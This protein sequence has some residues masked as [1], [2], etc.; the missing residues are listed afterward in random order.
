M[1][2]EATVHHLPTACHAAEPGNGRSGISG[3][4]NALD[5]LDIV[6][7]TPFWR[8]PAPQAGFRALDASTVITATAVP[9]GQKTSADQEAQTLMT[10]SDTSLEAEFE[11]SP[12]SRNEVALAIGAYASSRASDGEERMRLAVARVAGEARQMG[13]SAES[14]VLAV[15]HLFERAPRISGDVQKRVEAFDKFARWCVEAYAAGR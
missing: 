1:R 12:Q 15:K 6:S 11:L 3:A 2:E 13:V 4:G 7:E 8:D 5:A 10:T 9:I 14:M